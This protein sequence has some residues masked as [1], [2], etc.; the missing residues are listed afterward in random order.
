MALTPVWTGGDDTAAV[1]TA[2]NDG[3]SID[4]DGRVYSVTGLIGNPGQIIHELTLKDIGGNR[5]NMRTLYFPDGNGIDINVTI[6]R[7]GDPAFGVKN[8]DA[9]LWVEGPPVTGDNAPVYDAKIRARI[10]GA[11]RGC[12]AVF[13]RVIG[14]DIEVM[15]KEL[16]WSAETM[17]TDDLINGVWIRGGSRASRLRAIVRDCGGSVGGV[18]TKKWM[19]NIVSSKSEHVIFE[20]PLT[21]GGSVGL[22]LTGGDYN[23]L[24]QVI[25]GMFYEPDQYGLKLANSAYGNAATA[26]KIIR[27]GSHGVIVSGP[28]AAPLVLPAYNQFKGVHVLSPGFGGQY[29]AQLPAGF[30]V[31]QGAVS[32]SYPTQTE[33]TDCFAQDNQ[34]TKTMVDGFRTQTDGRKDSSC[35]S[36]GHTNAAFTGSWTGI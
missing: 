30:I 31:M 32:T 1:Q 29:A 21:M 12:G 16:I 4:G 23:Y 14:C 36:I 5:T 26:T 25:G 15:A 7:N 20:E 10:K 3:R 2:L 35:R 8:T 24:C 18:F 11:G 13:N 19:R 9:G 34:I 27:P 22:D 28:V 17:P 6:D 33:F